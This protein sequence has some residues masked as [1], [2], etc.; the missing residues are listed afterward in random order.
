MAS[1][2]AGHETYSERDME[3]KRMEMWGAFLDGL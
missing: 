3:R 2:Q 1:Y